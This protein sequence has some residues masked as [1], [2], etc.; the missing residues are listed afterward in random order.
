MRSTNGRKNFLSGSSIAVPESSHIPIILMAISFERE[1]GHIC[2]PQQF[3]V[4]SMCAQERNGVSPHQ[5]RSFGD[6]GSM[7]GLPESGCDWRFMSTHLK[8]FSQRP[9]GG[10]GHSSSSRARCAWSPGW[11]DFYLIEIIELFP[12]V[13]FDLLD[14]Q[15]T[16]ISCGFLR[17]LGE[18][19]TPPNAQTTPN[20]PTISAPGQGLRAQYRRVKT[21]E[22]YAH[23]GLSDGPLNS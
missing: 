22:I 19:R 12:T 4:P 21:L 16:Y 10:A 18:A 11:V 3:C 2:A 9:D 8:K 15:E 1:V 6:V 23:V 17:C 7:S 14:G 13:A 20:P 5:S